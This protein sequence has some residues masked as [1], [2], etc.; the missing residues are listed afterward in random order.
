MRCL[1]SFCCFLLLRAVSDRLKVTGRLIHVHVL[2][3]AWSRVRDFSLR[4]SAKDEFDLRMVGVLDLFN[5]SSA[6]EI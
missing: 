2:P 5:L 3:E 6:L 4:G 1:G